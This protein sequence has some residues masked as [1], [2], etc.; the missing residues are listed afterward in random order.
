MLLII[1]FS[2][3]L[4]QKAATI[5]NIAIIKYIWALLKYIIFSPSQKSLRSTLPVDNKYT[6]NNS[7]IRNLNHL[8]NKKLDTSK[9]SLP[10]N[11]L[12]NLHISSVSKIARILTYSILRGEE[13]P[14][15]LIIL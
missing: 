14:V 7:P 5:I 8:P 6:I 2:P 11:F 9:I 1:D 13:E 12:N 4:L 3:W 10:G 15:S